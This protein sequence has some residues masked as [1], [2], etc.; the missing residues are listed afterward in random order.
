MIQENKMFF[1]IEDKEVKEIELEKVVQHDFCVGSLEQSKLRECCRQ[2]GIEE[3]VVE[4]NG[5]AKEE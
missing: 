1:T 2:I 4:A 5:T 3:Y